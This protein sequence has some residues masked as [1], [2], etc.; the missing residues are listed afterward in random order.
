[1]GKVLN[2][3]NPTLVNAAAKSAGDKLREMN[4]Q[5]LGMDHV[6]AQLRRRFGLASSAG[7]AAQDARPLRQVAVQVRFSEVGTGLPAPR[8]P[9]LALAPLPSVP[10]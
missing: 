2:L 1:M 6:G 4:A 7:A 8:K 3:V 10:L 5:A 9:K